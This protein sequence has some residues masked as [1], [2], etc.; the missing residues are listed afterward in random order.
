MGNNSVN[1]NS[2]G[3]SSVSIGNV[4]VGDGT[5][6]GRMVSTEV[7]DRAV[8]RARSEL[9]NLVPSALRQT[10]AVSKVG[11]QLQSLGAEAGKKQPSR[12][13]G[14]AILRTIRENYSWAYPVLKDLVGVIWPALV[15]LL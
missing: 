11:E 10:D 8:A 4:V 6:V 5:Q 2:N 1:I 3:N 7:I 14:E 13:T 12:R 15:S 9:P